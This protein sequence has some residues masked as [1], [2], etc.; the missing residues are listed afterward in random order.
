MERPKY[1]EY[2]YRR[3]QISRYSITREVSVVLE[4]PA[5]AILRMV[6]KKR[7]EKREV[8]NET[9]TME[10]RVSDVRPDYSALVKTQVT[11][12]VRTAKGEPVG[13]ENGDPR[14]EFLNE[15]VDQ[16]GGLKEH[17]GT[18]PTPHLLLFP[19]E[20]QVTGSEWQKSRVE[21]IQTYS[22][23]GQTLGNAAVTVNYRCRL[24]RFAE[25]EGGIEFAEITFSGTGGLGQDSTPGYH[26]CEV[27]GTARFAIR[28]G[29]ILSAEVERVVSAHLDE[30]QILRTRAK[31]L[32]HHLS[33]GREQAVGGM[34]L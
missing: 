11:D 30:K 18:L 21:H 7:S 26:S 4:K 8:W 33:E 14:N 5:A 10:L 32:F 15:T 25:D 22:P 29:Y 31:E 3:D 24:E 27:S 34:R 12:A 2:R 9:W 28:D 6:G 17:A 20:P 16:F 13:Y 23:Q 1:L 19:E